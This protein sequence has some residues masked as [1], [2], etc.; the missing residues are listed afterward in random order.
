M[1]AIAGY[2]SSMREWGNKG[3][4]RKSVWMDVEFAVLLLISLGSFGVWLLG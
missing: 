1:S 2:A 4:A 3:K